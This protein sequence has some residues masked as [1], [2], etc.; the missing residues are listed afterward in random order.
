MIEVVVAAL[1][2][3]IGR[4]VAGGVVPQ[5]TGWRA[6][7]VPCK[8]FFGWTIGVCAAL[9]GAPALLAILAGVGAWAGHIAH[10]LNDSASM[11]R[12]G[13]ANL[14]FSWRLFALHF[15]GMSAY[16]ICVMLL[17]ILA[18]AVPSIALYHFDGM[19]AVVLHFGWFAWTLLAGA[20]L[21]APAYALAWATWN[22]K[23]GVAGVDGNPLEIA[24]WIVGAVYGVAAYGV[25]A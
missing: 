18:A 10:G 23:P 16:G 5:F 1:L 25:M 9:G 2:G 19:L 17:G 11:G 8:L 20:L 15:A 13:P 6:P 24:E 21:T 14:N 12:Y 3:A 7:G 4:R 22:G